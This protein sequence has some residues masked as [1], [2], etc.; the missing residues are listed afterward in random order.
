M[1]ALM[2]CNRGR[3]PGVGQPSVYASE[4]GLPVEVQGSSCG[5]R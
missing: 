3:S 4:E 1:L 5:P 2:N